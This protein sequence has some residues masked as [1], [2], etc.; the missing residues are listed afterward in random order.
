MCGQARQFVR[1]RGD[2]FIM[3]RPDISGVS[4]S[5]WRQIETA[6]KVP[7][8]LPPS[9]ALSLEYVFQLKTSGVSDSR[10]SALTYR[11]ASMVCLELMA[12]LPAASW[13]NPPNDQSKPCSATLLSNSGAR[14]SPQGMPSAL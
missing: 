1:P 8:I 5:A 7:E 10:Y 3:M 11:S 6:F 9:I 14:P 13:T 12:T 4:C 2:G